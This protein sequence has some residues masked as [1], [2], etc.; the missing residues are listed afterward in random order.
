MPTLTLIGNLGLDELATVQERATKILDVPESSLNVAFYDP[1]TWQRYVSQ[2]HP[3]VAALQSA[4]P[5][6]LAGA[7]DMLK[8]LL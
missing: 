1:A 4:Q 6:I 2:Q 3:T 7:D 5:E 8:G